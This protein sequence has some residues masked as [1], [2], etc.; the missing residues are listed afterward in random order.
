MKRIG[1]LTIIIFIILPFQLKSQNTQIDLG[2][3]EFEFKYDI[4][5]YWGET[6]DYYTFRFVKLSTSKGSTVW[7]SSF[8]FD[9]HKGGSWL[10]RKGSTKYS[11]N[12]GYVRQIIGNPKRK[13][14]A[15]HCNKNDDPHVVTEPNAYI[16]NL[17]KNALS[18][19]CLDHELTE[20]VREFSCYP[21]L[22][23][24]SQSQ[25]ALGVWDDNQYFPE[26]H[27]LEIEATQ[28]FDEG[29][30]KWEYATQRTGSVYNWQSIDAQFL[31]DNK[32]TFKA[33]AE[34]LF[35][36]SV[37]HKLG[38]D[39]YFRIKYDENRGSQ[40]LTFKIAPS[41]PNITL[42]EQI[43]PTCSGYD[44]GS[45]L[46]ELDR[47]IMD[48]E[49]LILMGSGSPINVNESINSNNQFRVTGLSGTTSGKQYSLQLSGSYKTSGM[50]NAIPLFTDGENHNPKATIKSPEP[51]TFTF[52]SLENVKCF[53]D[54]T[55]LVLLEA[56]G[57]NINPSNSLRYNLHWKQKDATSFQVFPFEANSSEFEKTGLT[58]DDYI[59]YVT[60]Y[61]GCYEKGS[62]ETTKELSVKIE[63]PKAPISIIVDKV[64][65]AS[66]FG[67]NNGE[68]VLS[69]QGGTQHTAPDKFYSVECTETTNGIVIIE[70]RNQKNIDNKLEIT[71]NQLKKG[72]YTFKIT[73]ANGCVST[74]T[75][76]I[77]EPKAITLSTSSTQNLCNG[78]ANAEIRVQIAGGVLAEN[79]AYEIKWFWADTD[80]P[81][82]DN[83]QNENASSAISKLKEGK[84]KIQITDKSREPNTL[85][86][87]FPIT[88][89]PK[90][91]FSITS[92]DD[93]TC[94]NGNDG[95]IKVKAQGGV[96]RYRVSYH[97]EGDD[98]TP[99]ILPFEQDASEVTIPNL[100]TGVYLISLVDGN[101]CTGSVVQSE[102]ISIKVEI[103]EP[104]KLKL[105]RTNEKHPTGFGRSDGSITYKISGGTQITD[106]LYTIEWIDANNVSLPSVTQTVS[107][108]DL[109][110]TAN[111]LPQ[112]EYTIIVKDA[113]YVVNGLT[114]CTT[115]AFVELF[116]P[117][118]LLAVATQTASVDCHGFATGQIE[119]KV[120]GGIII[121]QEEKL[122][123][124]YEWV[125]IEKGQETVL[126]DQVTAIATDLP[127]GSYKVNITD[128]SDPV[129]TTTSNIIEITQPPL[130][131]TK[132]TL[133]N[134][135]C[136]S[137]NDGFIHIAVE[138]GVGNYKLFRKQ[139][140]VDKAFAEYPIEADN[141]TFK[142]DRLIAG[143]Y[144]IYIQ[145]GND[146]YAK[147]LGEDIKI[148]EITQ[149]RKA[150]EI[151]KMSKVEPSGFGLSN[152]SITISING[153][154]PNPDNSYNIVWK[155]KNGQ[156]ILT[157]TQG[158]F[159]DGL[160]VTTL[161]NQPDGEY[162]V[163]VRDGNYNIAYP[164]ANTCCFVI[165][166]YKLT[167]PAKLEVA[168]E[169]TQVISCNG[170]SDGELTA[171]AT[172]GYVNTN[173]SGLPYKYKWYKQTEGGFIILHNENTSVLKNREVGTYK[174]EIEDYSRVVNITS[175][176]FILVEP[177]V[178]KATST[179]QLI[180]CGQTIDVVVYPT[181]GTKPYRYEWNTGDFTQTLEDRHP[182]K[183]FAFITDSRGCETTTIS[184]ITTPSNLAVTG[185]YT[186]P[187]CYKA[188]NGTIT[189]SVTGGRAPY[190]YQWSNGATTMNLQN[191]IAG[192]Y[193]VVVT[194]KDGCSYSE[195]FILEDP[196]QLTVDLG[197]ERTLCNGQELVLTPIVEDPNTKFYWTSDNGFTSTKSSVSLTKEGRYQLTITD[198]KGCV[199][200]DDINVKV[201]DI[202][203]S[204]EI[205]V[206]SQVFV[207]DT[208][209][210]VNI[211]NPEPDRIEW[212]FNDKDPIKVTQEEQHFAKVV[213]SKTGN[214]S[215]GIRSHVGSCYQD[216]I[217]TI[218]V[219]EEDDTLNDRFKESLIKQFYITP[220]P[221]DG[222]FE[223]IVDL[224]KESAIRLRVINLWNGTTADD[225]TLNG[226][227]EYKVRYSL[228][229]TH[230]NI[231]LVLLETS[232][233]KMVLRMLVQ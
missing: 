132:P 217:K 9:W 174:V 74:I 63:E 70:E 61:K 69:I 94:H 21:V 216:V 47:D 121:Q 16:F 185:V 98:S 65:D 67:K 52:K 37:V 161:E 214:Y 186:D 198:S 144:E 7:V 58:K 205:V 204:S 159:M 124:I 180:T 79:E 104:T 50:V 115:T 8:D 14:T 48:G 97:L 151:V 127:A 158:D 231:Y 30:Y 226:Q 176:E 110:A 118:K 44:D 172:G 218:T 145:D 197:E 109:I 175:I 139:H 89:H 136:F 213:F 156:T 1:L 147:I 201:T 106:T 102:E 41:A 227:K 28:G 170:R 90:V 66:G 215:I 73:D 189:L 168:I 137:G 4:D 116:E 140:G 182:G 178:L 150:I 126:I 167:E 188:S 54:N 26:K 123:Y 101:D 166:T 33:T 53:G 210:I 225:R 29:I 202:D 142:L 219:V 143:K 77:N 229:L 146:C 5:F 223:A 190:T 95:S 10:T 18:W 163:E 114:G 179:Q 232:S 23:L 43:N 120:T 196:K 80:M 85:S 76:S 32:A 91:L 208:I 57:G 105:E 224:A 154:T 71:A 173:T 230:A 13:R 128:G 203:I 134:V 221:N 183:Y 184:K 62:E 165:T 211:S 93:V 181:G 24:R 193:T 96:G 88:D 133:R 152:G 194:D 72:T 100:T 51:L 107:G 212:L 99:Y 207:N 34:E 46:L 228:S 6:K 117:E 162:T 157:T 59:Y 49:S 122:P 187:I 60:D 192:N 113:N 75:Q 195:S 86:H 108:A 171:H 220:N 148:I 112:G 111:N 191:L 125:S 83:I 68:I 206:A 164:D 155:N 130:Q 19:W 119:V 92:S 78:D 199:A 15:T 12:E 64:V 81:I 138:G 20:R 160:F 42:V 3:A 31:R 35:K 39:V 38:N 84:Y 2:A 233:G 56:T 177:E 40:I 209:V 129:N 22:K 82:T 87:V 200:T 25:N 153:G 17:D 149:P 55:G 45:V 36:G 169:E 27:P 103:K 11:A 222:N 141:K 131:I 135:S